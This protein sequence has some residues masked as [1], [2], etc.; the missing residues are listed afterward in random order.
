[1]ITL[2]GIVAKRDLIENSCDISRKIKKVKK[3][4]SYGEEK[5]VMEAKP[6]F[7]SSNLYPPIFP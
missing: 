2:N 7:G 1:M 3:R 4:K 5:E 6:F